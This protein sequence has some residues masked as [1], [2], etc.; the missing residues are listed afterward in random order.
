MCVSPHQLP[1]R[2]SWSVNSDK[3]ASCLS[4]FILLCPPLSNDCIVVCFKPLFCFAPLFR[5]DEN[6]IDG[7][8]WYRFQCLRKSKRGN[9][10]PISLENRE[11]V[12][13]APLSV[14]IRSY[15]LS[16]KMLLS[17]TKNCRV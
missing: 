4:L 1:L 3:R 6:I 10:V 15:G 11:I 14:L 16:S 12:R 2:F 17:R 13:P 7:E 9:G 8:Y 5:L